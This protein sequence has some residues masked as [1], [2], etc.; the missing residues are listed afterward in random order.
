MFPYFY[1]IIHYIHYMGG[2]PGS[3]HT[4]YVE[5]GGEKKYIFDILTES[6]LIKKE[7][8]SWRTNSVYT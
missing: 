8:S 7:V 4:E 3:K 2:V 5:E 1:F 6:Q